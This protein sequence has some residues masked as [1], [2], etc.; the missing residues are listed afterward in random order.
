[1][2]WLPRERWFKLDS[3]AYAED[4]DTPPAQKL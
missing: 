1:M 3:L 4:K 2:T